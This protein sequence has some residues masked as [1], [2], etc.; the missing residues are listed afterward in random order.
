MMVRVHVT[1][2]EHVCRRL[3]SRTHKSPTQSYFDGCIAALQRRGQ[4]PLSL[5]RRLRFAAILNFCLVGRDNVFTCTFDVDRRNPCF[6]GQDGLSERR[7]S[8]LCHASNN[9]YAI[10]MNSVSE[11]VMLRHLH[12]PPRLTV[13]T[14]IWSHSHIDHIGDMSKFPSTTELVV[15]AGTDLGTYPTF[16]DAQLVESD[17]S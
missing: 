5:L 10:D 8:C 11:D 1:K 16:E 14:V 6:T 12:R 4:T 9:V 15:G 17:I 7:R 2:S 3:F 13:Q